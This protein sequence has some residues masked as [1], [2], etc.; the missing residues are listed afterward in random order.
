MITGWLNGR[1]NPAYLD[2]R[3]IV[4]AGGAKHLRLDPDY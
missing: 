2:E 1:T 4:A 3:E